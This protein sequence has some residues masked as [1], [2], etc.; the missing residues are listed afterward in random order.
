[1]FFLSML[2]IIIGISEL[3]QK[4]KKVGISYI[5]FATFIFYGVIQSILFR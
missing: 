1:M 2:L 4:R 3:R 5:L